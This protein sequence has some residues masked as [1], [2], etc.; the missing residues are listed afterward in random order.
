[1]NYEQLDAEERSELAALRRFGAEPGG[2]RPASGVTPVHRGA[3]IEAQRRALRWVV[4]G[5]ASGGT[6][7]AVPAQQLVWAR[8]TG[9]GRRTVE[10]GVEPRAGERVSVA[11][12]GTGDKP[13][14]DLPACRALRQPRT[15]GGEAADWGTPQ[16]LRI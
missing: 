13:R 5:G 4:S 14:D 10:R 12:R 16:G 2:N 3:G 9:P 1:M 6:A 8:G 7:K 15:T 11:Q